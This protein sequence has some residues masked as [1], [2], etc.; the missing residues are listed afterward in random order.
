LFSKKEAKEL[1][2]KWSVEQILEAARSFQV[3]R[4]IL[5]AA[6]LDLFGLL[7]KEPRSSREVAQSFG[8][9]LRATNI[10]L[11]ALA[12]L[13]LLEKGDLGYRVPENLGPILSGSSTESVSPFLK[14][15]GTLWK[16]WGAL[17]EVLK[18]GMPLQTGSWEQRSPQEREAFIAAMHVIGRQMA[19]EIINSISLERVKRILDVGGA[20]GTYAIAFLEKSM[21][22]RVTLLDLPSVIPLARKRLQEKGLLNRV[23]LVA[24][25]FEQDPLPQGHDMVFLSAIVHQNDRTQNRNLF[26]KAREALNQGGRI[27]IR[28]HVMDPSRTQPPAGALFAVN[29]LVST[30]GGTTYTF[31]ELQEDLE[32]AG[33]GQV[34]WIRVGEKMDSL[35]EAIRMDDQAP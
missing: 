19:S 33:F 13:G 35:V 25:D 3:S 17:N 30:R 32:S 10:F 5:S 24:A 29:M 11:D 6:E 8:L 18:T 26:A 23:D 1:S 20:S 14:H 7:G 4:L 15:M 28:D 16:R 21:D 12:G 31:Q 9:D 27:L 22:I 2:N 34:R